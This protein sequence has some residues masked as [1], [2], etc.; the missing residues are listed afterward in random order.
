[1]TRAVAGAVTKGRCS[2]RFEHWRGH[3]AR[4][5]SHS[6]DVGAGPRL[7]L[8][9]PPASRVSPR[10]GISREDCEHGCLT[11]APTCWL[12]G[13]AFPR[14]LAPRRSTE[15]TPVPH[16]VPTV[17]YIHSARL[18]HRRP[19]AGLRGRI[20]RLPSMALLL[21][22]PRGSSSV[23]VPVRSARGHVC[24]TRAISTGL[25]AFA[26]PRGTFSTVLPAIGRLRDRALHGFLSVCTLGCQAIVRRTGDTQIPGVRAATS[27]RGC[28]WSSFA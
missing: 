27:P 12:V 23:P 18:L 19:R 7:R 25:A 16:P 14:S 21:E 13:S 17:M 4:A 20:V 3:R 8:L 28:T 2:S 11:S 10:K 9:A 26:S 1:M 22:S 5:L 15:A 6:E 24:M